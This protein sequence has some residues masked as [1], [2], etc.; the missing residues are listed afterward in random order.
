MHG[1]PNPIGILPAAPVVDFELLQAQRDQKL[2]AEIIMALLVKLGGEVVLTTE[3]LVFA[4][5]CGVQYSDAGHGALRVAAK[6]PPG[7][8]PIPVSRAQDA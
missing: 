4:S 7:G 5:L 8:V 6:L 3:D 2:A 1:K